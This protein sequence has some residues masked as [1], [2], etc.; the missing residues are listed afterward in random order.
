MMRWVRILAVL[1]VLAS[2]TGDVQADVIVE[3]SEVNLPNL[4]PLAGNPAFAAFGLAFDRGS[5]YAIDSRFIGAGTDDRGITTVGDNVGGVI[6]T[7]PALLR[8][9]G[10]SRSC[11]VYPRCYL[12]A[13]DI[14]L[15]R[16]CAGPVND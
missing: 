3:F 6:F 12:Q 9:H 10:T 2:G 13:E 4:T 11:S 7:T 14:C 16:R 15:P 8:A 1:A 5:T